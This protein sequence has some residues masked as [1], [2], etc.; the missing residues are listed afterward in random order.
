MTWFSPCPWGHEDGFSWSRRLLQGTAIGR[1]MVKQFWGGLQ[2]DVITLNGY[3]THPETAKLK[4]WNDAFWIGSGLSIHNYDTNVFEMVKKGQIRVHVADV[5]HL[6]EQSVHLDNG[7]VFPAEVIVTATGWKKE[8]SIKFVNFG[9][10]GIGL[11]HSPSAQQQLATE[12]DSELL[13]RFPI[14]ATQP[15]LNFKPPNDPFRLYRFMVPPTRISDRNIA[16]AGMVSSVSTSICATAQALWISA[17][18]DGKLDRLV[19][20]DEEVTKEVML[21]T[22]WGKWC[23]PTGYGASLPDFVFDA[24]PYTDLMLRDLGLKVNRKPSWWK[25]ITE[26][27]GPEDYVGLV[28]EWS[29]SHR[30]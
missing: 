19:R 5:D 3:D 7:E 15:T 26:P 20:T 25:E 12:A 30:R 11:P 21:H 8:P 16:F 6:T 1:W 23:Q 4:P 27:Y 24:I 29:A 13:S 2:Q 10:A 28:S 22:S 18:F 17:F 14:L 9:S